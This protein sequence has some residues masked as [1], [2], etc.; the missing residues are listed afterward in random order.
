MKKYCTVFILIISALCIS[1]TGCERKVRHW[2]ATYEIER[3]VGIEIVYINDPFQDPF[4]NDFEILN[5][6][7][8][9]NYQEII[10][11]FESIDYHKYFA[12]LKSPYDYAMRITYD[13][14]E[15]DLVSAVEPGFWRKSEGEWK[16]TARASW[17][18]VNDHV[19]FNNVILKWYPE[20]KIES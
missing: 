12:S 10:D 17:L 1:L 15:F 14:G 5:I 19:H 20:L 7:E 8:K 18:L 9:E 2:Q 4:I 13:S 6:I 3:I 11:D 16:Y